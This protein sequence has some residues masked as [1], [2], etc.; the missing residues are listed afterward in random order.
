[1]N[2]SLARILTGSVLTTLLFVRTASAEPEGSVS[3]SAPPTITHPDWA[4]VPDA[5]AFLQAFPTFAHDIGIEGAAE[6]TCEV[7]ASG[8]LKGCTVVREAPEGLGFG[9]SLVRLARYFKLKPS[10]VGGVRVGGARVNIPARF[11]LASH[12][13]PPVPRGQET[14][15][16]LTLAR[17]LVAAEGLDTA[18]HDA[19]T[20]A[21]HDYVEK[22]RSRFRVAALTPE[23]NAKIQS[24]AEQVNRVADG[25]VDALARSAATGQREVDLEG[26]IAAANDPKSLLNGRLPSERRRLLT[27]TEALLEQT[28][29]STD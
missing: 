22:L 17:R 20:A 8:S 15:A 3:A 1:M 14:S 24:K 6:I 9:P 10:T 29:D 4:S 2:P 12:T 21:E 25:I 7:T 23:Q 18:V 5:N 11:L 16:T 28:M 13:S 19:A 26:A 27:E